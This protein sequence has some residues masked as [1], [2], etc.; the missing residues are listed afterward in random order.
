MKRT[1]LTIRPA[2]PRTSPVGSGGIGPRFV[3]GVRVRSNKLA[4][5]A[6]PPTPSVMAWCSLMITAERSPSHPWTRAIDHSGRSRS[7]SCSAICSAIRMSGRSVPSA[8]TWKRW[9]WKARSKLGSTSH[10]GG[11]G[12]TGFPMTRWRSLGTANVMRVIRSTRTSTSGTSSSTDIA[13]I[14]ERR[15]GS[16]STPHMTASKAPIRSSLSS[17]IPLSSPIGSPGSRL[18]GQLGPTRGR[19][20]L[21]SAQLVHCH[22]SPR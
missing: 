21:R 2:T 14:T 17:D 22:G 19:G 3:A 7:K 6:I 12:D 13:T 8:G 1:P 11:I 5:M 10:R 9:R 18:S 15:T 16:C 20:I 4:A